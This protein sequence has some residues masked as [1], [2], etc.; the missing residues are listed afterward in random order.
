MELITLEGDECSSAGGIQAKIKQPSF[1]S[2]LICIPSLA[3]D[4]I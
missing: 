3:G 2:A 4:L 1:R